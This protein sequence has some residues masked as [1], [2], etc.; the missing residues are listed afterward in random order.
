MARA[1]EGGW[2]FVEEGKTY[3][4]KEEGDVMMVKVLKNES[5]P[6]EYMFQLEVVASDGSI[7][8]GEKFSVS[9]NK[10][11]TGYYNGMSQFYLLPEYVPSPLGKPWPKALPGHENEGLPKRSAYDCESSPFREISDI[12]G[13]EYILANVFTTQK[14]IVEMIEKGGKLAEGKENKKEKK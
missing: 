1:N 3:Q 9:H 6:D 8:P 10:K 5:T 11:A 12:N 14:A 7:E 13:M 4:Y 2:D